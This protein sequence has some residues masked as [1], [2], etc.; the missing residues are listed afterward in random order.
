MGSPGARGAALGDVTQG[1]AA[2][3][4]LEAYQEKEPP[5]VNPAED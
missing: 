4:G 3:V 5:E 2:S 1:L